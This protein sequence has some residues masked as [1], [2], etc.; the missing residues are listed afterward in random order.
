[1][2]EEKNLREVTRYWI[3]KAE[4]SLSAALRMS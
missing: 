1:M 4:D 2:N 3:E